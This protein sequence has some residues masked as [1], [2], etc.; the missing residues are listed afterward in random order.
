MKRRD[1]HSRYRRCRP[2]PTTTPASRDTVLI[3]RRTEAPDVIDDADFVVA[4]VEC[5]A[6]NPKDVVV[7]VEGCLADGHG[8]SFF[9][10]SARL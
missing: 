6:H 10:R 1:T 2:S 8:V 3:D 9:S 5:L 7:V 4:A